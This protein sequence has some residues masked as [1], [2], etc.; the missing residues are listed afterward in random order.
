MMRIRT[1]QDD[2]CTTL[3]LEGELAGSGVPEVEGRWRLTSDS[4]VRSLRLDL[5]C[6]SYIDDSGKQLL[7]RMFGDGTELLVPAR[8]LHPSRADHKSTD[9]DSSANCGPWEPKSLR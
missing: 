9:H 5:R 7:S 3:R 2:H 1:D 8:G 4:G 6:V